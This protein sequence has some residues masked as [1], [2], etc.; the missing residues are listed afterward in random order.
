MV[1]LIGISSCEPQLGWSQM[2]EMNL[3]AD[4][5]N[6]TTTL[7]PMVSSGYGYHG[8]HSHQGGKINWKKLWRGVKR[9]F[10]GIPNVV[11]T[12]NNTFGAVASMIPHPAAQR[13][14]LGLN[15]ANTM[16][17][18][19]QRRVQSL[20]PPKQQLAI[21]PTPIEQAAAEIVGAGMRRRR[22]GQ[23]LLLG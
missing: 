3:E 8:H 18:D 7:E 2:D 21:M 13:A 11:S 10:G 15:Q 23:G 4:E 6:V 20:N 16:V 12:A 22:K 9:F 14:A 19:L 1:M 5:Q 17:Q